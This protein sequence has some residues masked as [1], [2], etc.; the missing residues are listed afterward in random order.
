MARYFPGRE[1]QED[2]FLTTAPVKAFPPNG[3]GQYEISGNVWELC[4]DWFLPKY[5][6]NSPAEDPK[7]P[8]SAADG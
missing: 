1:H 4:Q 8:P 2:D 7:A 5:Y 3:Y 6:R